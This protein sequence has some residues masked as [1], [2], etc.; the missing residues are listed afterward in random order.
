MGGFGKNQ[1]SG[2]YHNNGYKHDPH[3][4]HQKFEGSQVHYIGSNKCK[5]K[6][7]IPNGTKGTVLEKNNLKNK[8]QKTPRSL[9]CVDFGIHGVR[10]VRK[11]LL[12]F[13]D[14]SK[15]RKKPT[16]EEKVERDKEK[17]Q[18]Q[19]ELD[20]K[21]QAIKDKKYQKI[22]ENRKKIKDFREWRKDFL[23]EHRLELINHVSRFHDDKMYKRKKERRKKILEELDELD[24]R[25]SS[26]YV[27]KSQYM[28]DHKTNGIKEEQVEK[29]YN[30]QKMKDTRIRKFIKQ[31][32]LSIKGFFDDSNKN[33]KDIMRVVHDGSR[34]FLMDIA[35]KED[36]NNFMHHMYEN[37][38]M[39]VV[40]D[41][42][43]KEDEKK[44]FTY[45]KKGYKYKS[46]KIREYKVNS[47]IKATESDEI[48]LLL[49]GLY[50]KDVS[51]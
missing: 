48:N 21:K 6:M 39:V 11:E 36:Y 23:D 50:P 38:N 4:S 43:E 13:V 29:M 37:R 5:Q 26:E 42:D 15:A 45:D 2:P 35:S 44:Q 33:Y 8:L 17:I 34:Q 12:Q 47:N 22:L 20:E 32:L 9:L 7:N 49:W 18:L 27:Y 30:L 10:Y 28:L 24:E 46:P 31:E 41:E 25:Y 1:N 14:T 3:V 40:E 16:H 19:G 51:Y